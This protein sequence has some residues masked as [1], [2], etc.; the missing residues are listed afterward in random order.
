MES[1]IDLNNEIQELY[2][3][4]ASPELY[5]IL[6]ESGSLTSVLG[7]ITHENTDISIASIGLIQEMTDPNTLL[8]VEEAMALVDSFLDLQGI[9]ITINIQNLS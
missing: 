5:P 3:I 6:L 7:M 2:A 4:A 9:I 8:E 1:E